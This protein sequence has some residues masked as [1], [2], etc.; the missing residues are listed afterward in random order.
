[1][2]SHFLTTRRVSSR[3][4]PSPRRLR[5]YLKEYLKPLPRSIKLIKIKH[6]HLKNRF[7]EDGRDTNPRHP[8]SK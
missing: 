7:R 1:V 8:P 4:Y 5:K 2:C 6:K 3:E